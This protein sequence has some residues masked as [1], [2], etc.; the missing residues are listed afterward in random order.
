[1]LTHFDDRWD[2][3]IGKNRE[4][5]I[6]FALH[7]FCS[8][9]NDLIQKK[10]RFSVA[11]CGGFTPQSIYQ[12]VTSVDC[13][14][15]EK[16]FVFFSDERC[17]P[18]TSS[19][20]NYF[21]AMQSGFNK[22]AKNIFRME[23]ELPPEIAAKKYEM[24]IVTKLKDELFDLVL[25]GV[26]ED[27]HV[28]SLFPENNFS[29]DENHLVIAPFVKSKGVFRLS[30]SMKAINNSSH[31]VIYVFGKNKAQIV[32]ELFLK[33]NTALPAYFVGTKERKALWILD[34]EAAAAL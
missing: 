9:A 19:E 20:S 24:S 22:V 8:L 33:K 18:P 23:G 32:E 11:L 6:N 21:N 15:W 30:L 31:M 5:A 10:D 13:T 17:V 28:A 4:D 29:E 26:G 25:L 1:M 27:G 2:L 7:H 14:M 3:F 34:S 16:V 12:K